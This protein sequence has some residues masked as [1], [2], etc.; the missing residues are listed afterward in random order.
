[1]FILIEMDAS[2]NGGSAKGIERLYESIKDRLNPKDLSEVIVASHRGKAAV[3]LAELLGKQAHITSITEFVYDDETKKEMKKLNVTPVEKAN[4][5]IQDN[6]EMRET[7]LMFGSKIKAALE[8]A[9]IAKNMKI[10][11]GVFISVAGG[12]EGLN[13]ALL[14]NT[15]YPEKEM[16]SDPIKQLRVEEFLL[17]PS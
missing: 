14:L 1:M 6:R 9:V 16:I 7:L 13:T 8:V 11:K 3:K 17:L 2:V 15:E 4:L 5:P 12:E 10:V